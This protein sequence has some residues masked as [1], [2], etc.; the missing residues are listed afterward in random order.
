MTDIFPTMTKTSKK[1]FFGIA[2]VGFFGQRQRPGLKAKATSTAAIKPAITPVIATNTIASDNTPSEQRRP[3]STPEERRPILMADTELV[4]YYTAEQE[5]SF[6][7]A[8]RRTV[9][10]GQLPGAFSTTTTATPTLITARK[11]S[12]KEL[13]AVLRD[14]VQHESFHIHKDFGRTS[15]KTV[16]LGDDVHFDQLADLP[17]EFGGLLVRLFSVS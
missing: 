11:R 12:G 3:A 5:S 15:N 17:D 1:P 6:A 8:S 2:V 4:Q 9:T 10:F 13:W 7:I 16:R 14:H